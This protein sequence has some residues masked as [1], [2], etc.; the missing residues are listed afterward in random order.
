MELAPAP[1]EEGY[2]TDNIISFQGVLAR[3]VRITILGNWGNAPIS[4]L[5]K[6]R[7]V[8][9]QE[10]QYPI[11]NVRATS[12]GVSYSNRGPEKTVDG[13]GLNADDGHSDEKTDMWYTRISMPYT[14]PVYIQYKFDDVYE[15]DELRVWNHNIIRGIWGVTGVAIE[16]FRQR[17]GLDPF[18][19]CAVRPSPGFARIM[20]P[21]RSSTWMTFSAQYVRLTILDIWG[22]TANIGLSEVRFYTNQAPPP[23]YTLFLDTF[24]AYGDGT[25]PDEPRIVDMWFDGSVNG[26][27]SMVGHGVAPYV[28]MEAVHDGSQ[29]MP[30]FYDNRTSPYYLRDVSRS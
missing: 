8:A 23:S 2:V 14:D 5:S 30:L 21:T 10:P 7:F 20:P 28:E 26:T 19:E 18:R 11:A 12:N 17:C 24:E 1:G 22:I 29:S 3:F 4:G 15:L 25:D 13:S 9:W 27:G 16:Y 6:V